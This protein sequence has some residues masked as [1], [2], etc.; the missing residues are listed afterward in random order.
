MKLSIVIPAKNE[1]NRIGRT[2]EAY[3]KFFEK[4]KKSGKIE[5]FEIVIVINGCEDRTLDVVKK[6]EEKYRKIRHIE[7]ERAG[8]GFAIIE[9][10]RDSLK[11]ENS[12]I[13]FVDADM[14]TSPDSFYDL[15]E[16]MKDTK[17]VDGVIASRW[18]E[19]SRVTKRTFARKVTSRGFNFLVRGI[20]FLNFSDTQCGA[21]L[22]KKEALQE[23]IDEIGITEWAFDIDLLY[24]LKNKGFKIKEIPTVWVDKRDSRINLT[25]VPFRMFS[26]IIR[27]RLLYSPFKFIVS[28]YDKLPEKIKMHHNL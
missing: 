23:V 10:F 11:R 22:F 15:I 7:F 28:I 13:G 9:G 21:K 19:E 12:L 20:L 14:S 27:L 24:R 8:K 4:L 25:K 16:N 1:E 18:L 26:A 17:G 2:L 3:G 5:D 6:S